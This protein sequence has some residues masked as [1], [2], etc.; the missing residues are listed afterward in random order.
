M[1]LNKDPILYRAR[2]IITRPFSN[3]IKGT[4][5]GTIGALVLSTLFALVIG[6]QLP[7]YI[8]PR[9]LKL[10]AGIGFIAIGIWVLLDLRH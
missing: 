3:Q 7:N 4:N 9:T 2:K 6:G 5:E 8:S 1:K 10:A